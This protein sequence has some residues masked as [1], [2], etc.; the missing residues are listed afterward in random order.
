MH[1]NSTNYLQLLGKGDIISCC[2]AL[3]TFS[4]LSSKFSG[5]RDNRVSQIELNRAV[6]NADSQS[7]LLPSRRSSGNGGIG[8]GFLSAKGCMAWKEDRESRERASAASLSEPFMCLADRRN[9]R[10]ADR[11][12]K[13]LIMCMMSASLL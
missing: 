12:C 1:K 8:V 13:H 10:L 2:I 3:D 5:G 7:S 9:T 6:Q 11:K 4:D